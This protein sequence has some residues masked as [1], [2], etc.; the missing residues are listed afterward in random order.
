MRRGFTLIELLVVIAILAILVG[1]ALPFVQSYVQE[2]RIS[3]AKSDL[4]EISRALATYEMREKTYNASDVFQLDGRYLSKSPMDPWGKPYIVATSSGVVYSAGPDRI[5]LNPD[6]IVFPY[7]PP[8]A[9]SQVKWVDANHTG[10]VDTQNTPDQLLLMFSRIVYSSCT[11]VT[12]PSGAHAYFQLTGTDT[13]DAAFDW[14]SLAPYGDGRNFVVNLATG[15]SNAFVPG[16]DTLSVRTGLPA[17]SI[18]DTGRIPTLCLSSQD[19]I[20]QPQ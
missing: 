13:L 7:Q 9:L 3:K 17:N 14:T 6:D 4:E 5:P 18:T 11:M 1:A 10:Q 16:S 8:L 20:I 15:V 19:V 12:A 2:S